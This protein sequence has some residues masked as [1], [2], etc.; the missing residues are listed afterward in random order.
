[1]PH[2]LEKLEFH[3]SAFGLLP[4]ADEADIG[5]AIVAE[6]PDTRDKLSRFCTCEARRKGSCEHV[7]RLLRLRGA[8]L[9]RWSN[10][11]PQTALETS[12]WWRLGA[13]LH[14]GGATPLDRLQGAAPGGNGDYRIRSEH[15]ALLLHSPH[16]A[17]RLERLCERL[18]IA[19]AASAA[20]RLALLE[21]LALMTRTSTETTFNHRGTRSG[22]QVLESSFYGR[23]AYHCFLEGLSGTFHPRVHEESGD[24]LLEFREGGASRLFDLVVPRATVAAALAL[25]RAEF[26]EQADLAVSPIPLR[27]LFVVSE[28]T[29]LDLE[30]RPVIEALQRSGERRYLEGPDLE[31][32]RY[33]DLVFVK[34]LGVLAQLERPGSER[35]FKAPVSLKLAKSQ[36]GTFLSAHTVAVDEGRVVWSESRRPL[37]ILREPDAVMLDPA[38]CGRRWYWLSIRYGFGNAWVSLED[39][40]RARQEGVSHLETESGLV[41]V[42]APA[43]D[44]IAPLEGRI[45]EAG[46]MRVTAAE[47]LRIALAAGGNVRV[48]GE[49]LGR[50]PLERLLLHA[51]E[52]ESVDPIDLATPLRS[53]QRKG[54]DWLA[55]LSE[56]DLGG[57]LCDDMGLGKTHQAM[58]LMLTLRR[59]AKAI[60]AEPWRALVVAPT[61]VMSHWRDKLKAHAPDLNVVLHHGAG[62]SLQDALA[63]ADVVVTSYGVLRND[64]AAFAAAVLDL[65]ILDEIQHLKN[66][67]T[68]A[69]R[70]AA[71]VRARMKLGLTGTPIE[72]SVADVKALLDLVLPDYL[73]SNARFQKLYVDRG[74]HGIAD[75]RRVVSPFT[76]RRLKSDVLLELPEKIEDVRKCLL[77]D[78]QASLYREAIGTRA[79]PLVAKLHDRSERP[80][81][82]HIF[83][84]LTL[85][86]RICNHP[87]LALGELHDHERFQSGKWELFKELLSEALDA[88]RKVVVF[89]QFLGMIELFEKHLAKL[90]VGHVSLTGA[91]RDRGELVRRFNHDDGCRVF[92][93]S[94]KAGGTGIDLTAGSVVIHYDRW[95]NAAR[96]DQATDRVYRMGQNKAVSVLKLV[97]E[98]TLEEKIAAMI[99]DKRALANEV[100]DVDDPDARKQFSREELIALLAGPYDNPTICPS[101][102]MSM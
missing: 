8:L 34:E 53:Y 95:W 4:A 5:T 60:V 46:R 41:D 67:Q 9:E 10:D 42:H 93:G 97:T 38:A 54:L 33:G 1:M 70:A 87:A 12:L 13:L 89:T 68:Q 78:D 52:H 6:L 66:P 40:L 79:A 96:E 51:P 94:L 85:L 28:H 39:L 23:L 73:G 48:E 77:S 101:A 43:L 56:N 62:R 2:T 80:P 98:G 7:K 57:L 15:G 20:P 100:I 24:F 61:T 74:A 17:A 50:K 92:L 29:E 22:L 64:A 82:L 72:N 36:L 31:K 88:D 86:K 65:M 59:S 102:S 19:A 99:E 90:D 18:G 14:D 26:R 58:A 3:R 69:H 44:A 84:L 75:L 11:S 71:A 16:P 32:F 76:L 37:A 49:G 63:S 45:S 21:R 81:Y 35:R 27:S 91:S 47:T 30:V 25:L 55:F 83:A